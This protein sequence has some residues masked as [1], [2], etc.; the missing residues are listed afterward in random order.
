MVASAVESSSQLPVPVSKK[1]SDLHPV[2]GGYSINSDTKGEHLLFARILVHRSRFVA[3]S[4]A[5]VN[6]EKGIRL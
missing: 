3:R 4:I 2:E 1:S 5:L 6:I